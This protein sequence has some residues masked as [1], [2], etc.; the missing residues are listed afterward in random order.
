VV[1][2]FFG[3]GMFQKK[4]CG[5]SAFVLQSAARL[6]FSFLKRGLQK[7]RGGSKLFTDNLLFVDFFGA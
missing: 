6:G 7:K 3:S 4:I 2:D 5:L 1:E